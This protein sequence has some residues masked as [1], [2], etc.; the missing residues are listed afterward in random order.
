MWWLLLV[1]L[2]GTAQTNDELDLSIIRR[3]DR[4][5]PSQ[6][7][8]ETQE[9]IEYRTQNLRYQSPYK[10]VPLEKILTSET[11]Y[12]FI[13]AGKTLIRLEDEKAFRTHESIYAK[14]YRREDEQGFKYIQS[15]NGKCL[16]KILSKDFVTVQKE[17]ELYEPPAR[18]TPAPTNL[19][20]ADIDKKLKILPEFS[21]YFATV[22]GSFMRDLF[23]DKAAEEGLSQQYGMH[24]ATQWNLPIKVGAVVHFERASYDLTGGGKIHYSA[25]SAGPQF[26]TKDFQLAAIPLRV[27]T[28]FRVSPLARARGQTVNGN[29]NFK[30]N[31]ADFMLGLEHPIRNAVGEFVLGVFYQQQWLNIKDQSEIVSIN[32]SNETNNSFGLSLAQVF[33]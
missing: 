11:E 20:K 19:L 31:S 22:R 6:N 29:V 9:D 13:Q 1:P 2:L 28:Q 4:Q 21:F 16:Y 14:F 12:G 25:L 5:L 33:E 15:N 23:N 30:F 17:L 26:K 3:L 10:K 18:Y 27:Q 24:F 7:P 8:I 32:A